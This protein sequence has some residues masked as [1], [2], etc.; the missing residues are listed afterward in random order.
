MKDREASEQDLAN[1]ERSVR[2][3]A[4]AG[5]G[6]AVQR[7]EGMTLNH[8]VTFWRSVHRADNLGS[9]KSVWLTEK[10]RPSGR[11]RRC[12]TPASP[13]WKHSRT[14]IHRPWRS[15]TGDGDF[16]RVFERLVPIAPRV[17]HAAL[18]PSDLSLS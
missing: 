2:V 11:P 8:L 10:T 17:R 16:C 7:F 3:F 1:I 5:I 9:A 18:H 14:T 4:D 12:G 6:R 13:T 15:S